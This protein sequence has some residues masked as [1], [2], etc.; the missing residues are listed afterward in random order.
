MLNRRHI[1]TGSLA[2]LGGCAARATTAPSGGGGSS[3]PPPTGGSGGTPIGTITTV[4]PHANFNGTAG[5]GAAAPTDPA[6]TGAK[7]I[8]RIITCPGQRVSGQLLLK[9]PC[10]AYGGIAQVNL[11]GDCAATT[12]TGMSLVDFVDVN[13]VSRKEF[14]HAVYLDTAAFVA[15]GGTAGSRQ[16]NIYAEI[17]PTNS[18][19]QRRVLSFH[20]YPEST[21]TDGTYN[22]G[23]GQTY[24][25]IRAALNQARLDG[26][27]APLVRIKTTG[28]YEME[29]TTWGIYT[30][31]Q[32]FAVI[33]HDPGVVAT[34]RRAA[35]FNPTNS[36]SWKWTPGWDGIEFRG[37][38]IVLDVKNTTEVTTSAKPCLFN[39][40]KI[41]NSIGTRD[42][43]YWNK[44]AR[45]GW[46]TSVPSWWQYHDFEFGASPFTAQ[47]GVVGGVSRGTFGDIYS[48]TPIVYG[49]HDR[50]SSS[51]Y[52]RQAIPSM[53]VRYSGA[54]AGTVAK[55]GGNGSGYLVLD[56]GNHPGAP[57]NID[58]GA[59]DNPVDISAV[60]ASINARSGWSATVQDA[61]RAARYLIGNGFGSANGFPATDAKAASLGLCTLVDIH[62]DGTQTYGGE[63][64]Y[65]YWN[66]TLDG[67]NNDLSSILFFDGQ[68]SSL[69][70]RDMSFVNCVLFSEQSNA[71]LL[72]GS[73]SHHKLLRHITT[74]LWVTLQEG[75][76]EVYTEMTNSICG[77]IGTGGDPTSGPLVH[78]YNNLNTVP[79]GASAWKLSTTTGNVSLGNSS[80][81]DVRS[82][83]AGPTT[84]NF[85]PVNTALTT[86]YPSVFP[87][88][89]R[90]VARSASD[91]AGAWS[92]NAA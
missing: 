59:V 33:T 20:F 8:G 49:C 80:T 32:G 6:R 82:C 39:G 3:P 17:V 40:C 23:S 10:D 41:T 56:D 14:Y 70:D 42:T 11:S 7:A 26:R 72:G 62:G 4:G 18:T 54:G 30:G 31:G 13:G 57:L 38:G 64:N 19:V 28:F 44:G 37:S 87:Y 86:L 48:H 34:L 12:I 79:N 68:G 36:A 85:A 61:S 73:G 69:G 1:L 81:V 24:A 16:A 29:D 91:C 65:I 43:L 9:I 75:T 46:G 83:V 51:A 89:Q 55:T 58:L 27:K 76:Q 74:T 22:V 92:K 50:D 77:G 47:L 35:A 25:T 60:A 52:F 2:L 88:D 53:T 71:I 63:S 45:P 21:D 5:S 66:W 84:N 78:F 67:S 15:K 90:G